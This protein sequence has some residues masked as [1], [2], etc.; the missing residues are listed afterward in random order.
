MQRLTVSVSLSGLGRCPADGLHCTGFINAFPPP[1]S[2]LGPLCPAHS[3]AHCLACCLP[4][5]LL[6]LTL[7]Q[8]QNHLPAGRPQNFICPPVLPAKLSWEDPSAC[9]SFL[10]TPSPQ[11][12]SHPHTGSFFP[13]LVAPGLQKPVQSPSGGA[14]RA[15]G[16]TAGG[17][18]ARMSVSPATAP[19][20]FCEEG[21]PAGSACSIVALPLH[22]AS[23]LVRCL[24]I[25]S[26]VLLRNT[27]ECRSRW[28]G[29]SVAAARQ[30]SPCIGLMLWAC[31]WSFLF[32]RGKKWE[33]KSSLSQV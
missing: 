7:S 27:G 28:G 1:P 8:P 13:V 30:V 31:C 16:P 10:C 20:R 18:A 26:T 4:A 9:C 15:S 17:V 29:I 22:L 25:V 12:V 5:Q 14:T 21:L 32:Q 3:P 2:P 24:K 19:A 33:P 11:E 23:S 6:Q